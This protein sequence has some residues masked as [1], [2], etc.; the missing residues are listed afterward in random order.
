M[1]TLVDYDP[2]FYNSEAELLLYNGSY[3]KGL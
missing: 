3:P 2:W 1:L